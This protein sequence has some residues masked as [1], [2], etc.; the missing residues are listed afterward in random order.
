MGVAWTMP[1]CMLVMCGGL[2]GLR[3]LY[4]SFNERVGDGCL[5][6]IAVLRRLTWLCMHQTGATESGLARLRA[7]RPQLQA[8]A[9]NEVLLQP[10]RQA[11]CVRCM[12]AWRADDGSAARLHAAARKGRAGL[13]DRTHVTCLR[14]RNGA[15]GRPRPAAGGRPHLPPPPA[16]PVIRSGCAEAQ[17][18]AAGCTAA[19][20]VLHGLMMHACGAARD[21]S[22]PSKE[23]SSRR[24]GAAGRRSNN[25]GSSSCRSAFTAGLNPASLS[26]A[27]GRCCA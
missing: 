21:E 13:S 16:C 2:T 6:H 19:A 3:R 26:L 11:R 23:S 7:A 18:A 9:P 27:G 10:T 14:R 12:H 22:T 20:C 5:E 24:G 15:A 1:A 8:E 4:V 17:V 25:P